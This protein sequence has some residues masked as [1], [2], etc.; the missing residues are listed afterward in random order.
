MRVAHG[1]LAALPLTAL[2]SAT[3][4]GAS[5]I[6]T[7]TGPD[8]KPFMGAFV[9][10]EN[11]QSRMTVNVLSDA[12]GRYHIDNLPAATYT[13]RVAAIGYKSEP[14][15]SVALGRRREGLARLCA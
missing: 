8:G 1:M 10:A 4:L 7:V 6:G 12:Q 5:I 11:P 2:M 15:G 3:A 14:R 13:V 9:A